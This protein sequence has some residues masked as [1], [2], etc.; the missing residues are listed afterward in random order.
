MSFV[1]AAARVFIFAA[2]MFL[3]AGCMLMYVHCERLYE[4]MA[5]VRFNESPPQR[6]L[7]M[8]RDAKGLIRPK[9]KFYDRSIID[10][11]EG[12]RRRILDENRDSFIYSI[13]VPIRSSSAVASL[14]ISSARRGSFV[15]IMGSNKCPRRE[16]HYNEENDTF[17]V[18]SS[19]VPREE[20]KKRLST[21][22]ITPLTPAYQSTD[23]IK[24]S[25]MPLALFSYLHEDVLVLPPGFLNENS[26]C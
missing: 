11:E 18:D 9:V 26:K 24:I 7:S 3:I 6:L 25:R 23:G 17:D 10:S 19:Q 1:V 15:S 20:D 13:D 2:L 16:S 22:V 12:K 21:P 4:T 5:V 8:A 14:A